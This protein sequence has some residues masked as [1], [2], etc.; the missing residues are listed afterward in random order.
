[1]RKQVVI[2][3]KNFLLNLLW[4]K[5]IWQPDF[6]HSSVF[7]KWQTTSTRDLRDKSHTWHWLPPVSLTVSSPHLSSIIIPINNLTSCNDLNRKRWPP[8]SFSFFFSFRL[9]EIDSLDAEARC[10]HARALVCRSLQDSSWLTS[11]VAVVHNRWTGRGWSETRRERID[12]GRMKIY[13]LGELSGA[14]ARLGRNVCW[15]FNEEV[16]N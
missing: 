15:G 5:H 2:V 9:T 14:R 4:R 16:R 3:N 12:R 10:A 8:I 1:M 7:V 6:T 13:D 11:C